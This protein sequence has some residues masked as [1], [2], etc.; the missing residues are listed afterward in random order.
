MGQNPTMTQAPAS[1]VKINKIKTSIVFC[2]CQITLLGKLNAQ[3][4]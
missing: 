4:T 2:T 3:I 1:G